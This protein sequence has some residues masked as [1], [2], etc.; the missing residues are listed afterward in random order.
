MVLISLRMLRAIQF[1]HLLFAQCGVGRGHGPERGRVS[2][3]G[4]AIIMLDIDTG[5]MRNLGLIAENSI[6]NLSS[7][8]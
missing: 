6:E 5:T 2:R 8:F 4:Q 3:H 7:V 1:L